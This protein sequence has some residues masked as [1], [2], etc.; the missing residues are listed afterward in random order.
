MRTC[1]F[2]LS[3]LIVCFVSQEPFFFAPLRIQ[4]RMQTELLGGGVP[5]LNLNVLI[6][7]DLANQS[8]DGIISLHM[9]AIGRGMMGF[10]IYQTGPWPGLISTYRCSKSTRAL[11]HYTTCKEKEHAHLSKI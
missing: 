5:P 11:R 2:C 3:V 7:A 4:C 1:G 6:A 9:H 8:M 10:R